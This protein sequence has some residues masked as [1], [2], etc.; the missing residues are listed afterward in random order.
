MVGRL[1][2]TFLTT[3]TFS[4]AAVK[5]ATRDGAT[6]IDLVDGIELAENQEFGLGVERR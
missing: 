4:P 6:P 5:E 3:G 1:K 2:G